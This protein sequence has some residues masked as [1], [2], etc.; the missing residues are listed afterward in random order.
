GSILTVKGIPTL[1]N[2]NLRNSTLIYSNRS[3]WLLL[4]L[5]ALA[6]LLDHICYI[7]L[8]IALAWE[9]RHVFPGS[10]ALLVVFQVH[11]ADAFQGQRR[12]AGGRFGV[13]HEE[14]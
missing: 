14:F 13:S 3:R 11:P 6:N 5:Q 2:I 10:A 8:P 1:F 4:A 12:E 7:A 9:R